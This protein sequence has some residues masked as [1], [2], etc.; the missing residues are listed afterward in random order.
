MLCAAAGKERHDGRYQ[1]S[2]VQAS[3]GGGLA[4]YGQV[5]IH[6]MK[7]SGKKKKK[8]EQ[9]RDA[10][11]SCF[12][13]LSGSRQQAQLGVQGCQAAATTASSCQ[14]HLAA[15]YLARNR[16]MGQFCPAS[17]ILLYQH[18]RARTHTPPG[19]CPRLGLAV[20]VSP[21]CSPVH[22]GPRRTNRC[23]DQPIL[24][25][26][27]QGQDKNMPRICFLKAMASQEDC[28]DTAT[29]DTLHSPLINGINFVI[30]SRQGSALRWASLGRLACPWFAS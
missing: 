10:G 1:G 13:G 11:C 28:Q 14:L 20:L 15:F 6:C 16:W 3:N 7:Q 21:S 22:S 9:E 29:F 24:H 25:P 30:G 17:S 8:R 4:V 2:G 19:S 26:I 5:W 23:P 18:T 12:G 27:M